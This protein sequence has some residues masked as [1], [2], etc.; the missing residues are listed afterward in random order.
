M[1]FYLFV[2]AKYICNHSLQQLTKGRSVQVC[3]EAWIILFFI[4]PFA[5]SVDRTIKG[6]NVLLSQ[7]CLLACYRQKKR[8][9]TEKMMGLPTCLEVIAGGDRKG[10][11][12]FFL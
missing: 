11:Y 6:E 10:G 1:N 2:S 9:E 5:F 7:I 3:K 8:K 4:V 12:P